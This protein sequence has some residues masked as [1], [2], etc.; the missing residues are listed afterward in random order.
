MLLSPLLNKLKRFEHGFG[1]RL[2]EIDQ[3]AMA[4]L[5]QVHSNRVIR[6]ER[7]SCAGEG[8]ALIT[9][10][11]GLALS[12]RTADCFPILLADVRT[13]AVAAI[14]AGWRGTHGRIVFE[15]IGEMHAQFATNAGDLIAAIG[16]GIGACCYQVGEEVARLFGLGGRAKVDLAQ[17]NRAQLIEC[18]VNPERIE[19]NGRCT[20]CEPE[21]F[22][23]Y[24]REGE[25]AG[26]MVSF[27][28][29]LPSP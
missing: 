4:S 17:E 3:S 25:K 7:E 1:T 2:D 29:P 20:F 23:S 5:R 8:D 22:Y 13:G 10:T 6:V 27:I 11:P 9:Q 24:R 19:S 18:G 15:T 14:H 12:V 21:I 16:P 28:R 26:R